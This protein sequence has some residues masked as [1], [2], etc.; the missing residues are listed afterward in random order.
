MKNI[1]LTIAAAAALLLAS[2][3]KTIIDKGEKDGFLSFAEFS[4]GLDESLIT[5]ADAAGGNYAIII[6][7]A[8]GMEVMRK[9]YDEVRNAGN[10]L[11]LPAGNYTLVARSVGEDVPFAVF[12]RP[13]YGTSRNFTIVAGQE[14]TIG[15]LVCTLLQCKVTVEYSDEFLE[16][17][18]G[19]GSTTVTL[20]EGHP[21]EYALNADKTYEHQAGYFAV[22]GSTMTVVFKGN[23]DGKT[24]KMTKSFA[25]IAAKQ[26]RKIKFVQMKNEQG[27]ATFDIVINDLISDAT[28]NNFVGGTEVIIGE[29][30]DAPKGDG[31]IT[32]VPDYEAGCDADITDLTNIVILPVETR[33][34]VIKFKATVPAGVKK[35]TVD[36]V[37]DNEAFTSAVAAADATSLDLINPSEQNGII[38]DVVPFPHGQE[39]LGQTEIAFDLSAAQDAIVNY[40]G[41]HSFS[42][43]IVDNDGCKNVIP[44]T[45]VVE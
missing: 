4:L 32:L 1:I 29:D 6:N 38:F 20:S 3:Q 33:D 24:Q 17:V 19:A 22:N 14:T 5:K 41:R 45:M 23:I 26:W 27:Q 30:P 42:M 44:V 39:L 25:G 11:T 8:E 13:I 31:G 36:I 35:F 37:S 28:L 43:T 9:T 7:D 21:L 15:E 18:T 2:C 40:K 16:C 34:M 12:E 10:L